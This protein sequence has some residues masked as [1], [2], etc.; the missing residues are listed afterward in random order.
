MKIVYTSR[1]IKLA[2]LIFLIA[3]APVLTVE[4][5]RCTEL[6]TVCPYNYQGVPQTLIHSKHNYI[7]QLVSIIIITRC[8]VMDSIYRSLRNW[9]GNESEN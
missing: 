2:L 4:S 3:F 5:S 9:Q 1:W 6:Q 7:Q 8:I